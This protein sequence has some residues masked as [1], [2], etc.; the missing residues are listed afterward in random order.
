MHLFCLKSGVFKEV[1]HN[2]KVF[3]LPLCKVKNKCPTCTAHHCSGTW[4]RWI[5]P[6]FS[7]TV[8]WRSFVTLSA[9]VVLNFSSKLLPSCV[10][11]NIYVDFAISAKHAAC[12][13]HLL[14][15]DVFN[16]TMLER[17]ISLCSWS[18]F[19]SHRCDDDDNIKKGEEKCR[20]SQLRVFRCIRK[21]AKS[22]Y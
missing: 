14:R 4:A 17:T 8:S 16:R 20:L 13:V 2:F 19:S 1:G 6:A 5:Y 12:S 10:M 18:Q 9:Y 7:C 3:R 21:I 11:T 15:L 22:N